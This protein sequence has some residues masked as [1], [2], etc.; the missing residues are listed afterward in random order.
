MHK[1]E[2]AEAAGVTRQTLSNWMKSDREVL[3]HMGVGL[4]QKILPPCAVKYLCEKYDIE[5]GDG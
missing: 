1:C 3:E 4:N 5:V 2:L